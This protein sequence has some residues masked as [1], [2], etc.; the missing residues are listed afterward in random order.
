VVRRGLWR[1]E[2]RPTSWFGSPKSFRLDRWEIRMYVTD[3]HQES[4][5][6]AARVLQAAA[7]QAEADTRSGS[8]AYVTETG[9]K[10]LFVALRVAAA[11]GPRPG[12]QHGP[13]PASAGAASR[14]R[15]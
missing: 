13:W 3:S 5:L 12:E 4:L 1:V 7:D 10:S 2:K 6:L 11:A 8:R 9:V 15:D 14:G